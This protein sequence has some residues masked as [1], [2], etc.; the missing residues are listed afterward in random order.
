MRASLLVTLVLASSAASCG[1]VELADVC[2]NPVSISISPESTTLPAGATAMYAA[3]VSHCPGRGGRVRWESSNPAVASVEATGDT[4]A[5]VTGRSSGTAQIIATSLD[6]ETIKAA[7]VVSVIPFVGIPLAGFAVSG[8]VV[9]PAGAG[10][11]GSRVVLRLVGDL[12][13]PPPDSLGACFGT[14]G[15]SVR[16]TLLTS[17]D[18]AFG[19]ALNTARFE[20]HGCVWAL[21]IPPAAS[22]LDSAVVSGLPFHSGFE[23]PPSDTVHVRLVLP[24]RRP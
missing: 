7:G 12:G 3:V 13:T 20:M 15:G 9:D 5:T 17:S 2:Q 14:L 21:A 18:G 22:G 10:V 19:T 1:V 4:S 16:D 6:D 8:V 23:W 24:R 11:P